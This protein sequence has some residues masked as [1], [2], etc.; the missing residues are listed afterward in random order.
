MLLAV[1]TATKTTTSGKLYCE[2]TFVYRRNTG[3][4][5]ARLTGVCPDW[6]ADDGL[7]PHQ[8]I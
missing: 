6:M 3:I 4:F 8:W 5:Q 2:L 7:V 1:V